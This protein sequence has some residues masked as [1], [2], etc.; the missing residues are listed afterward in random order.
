[1]KQDL[2]EVFLDTERVYKENASLQESIKRTLGSMVF[3]PEG[4]EIEVPDSAE[5]SGEGK[6]SAE[7]TGE[8]TFECARRLKSSGCD[9]VAVLNFASS[10]NPG[11]GVKSGS[12]AQ[13]ECLCRVSTL[14]PV[15]AGKFMEDNYYMPNRAKGSTMGSDSILW[16]P[17]VVVFKSDDLIPEILPQT[18]WFEADVLTC[19]APNLSYG[20]GSL[21]ES[22]YDIH[23]RRALRI[24]KAAAIG[25]ADALVLG[26]FGCGA[27]G[28]DPAVVARAYK[29]AIE[30]L[31][32]NLGI[33][34]IVFAIFSRRG[35]NIGEF[36]E[37]FG[38]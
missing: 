12:G 5:H 15:L 7:I 25:G 28:N 36:K 35:E 1:M 26:A 29:D 30:S 34:K 24:I 6:P 11:G 21:D 20:K 14:Y 9:R 18:E 2:I 27:F 19:A 3:Y 4:E 13:E 22:V 38:Q 33:K 32:G 37:V 16:A 23:R 10:I 17:R 8:R 31:P